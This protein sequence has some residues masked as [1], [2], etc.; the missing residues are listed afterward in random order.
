MKTIKKFVIF[1]IL[2]SLINI[3]YSQ[4]KF[5]LQECIDYAINNNLQIKQS[6]LNADVSEATLQQSKASLFPSLNANV[7]HNYNYGKTIDPFTNTFATEQVQSNSFSVS[8][9]VTIFHG[10]QAINTIKQ[11]KFNYLANKYEIEKIK[12]DISLSIAA[13]YLQILFSEELVNT[14]KNQ[15]KITAEKR[16]RIKKFVDAGSLAKSN[17]LEMEAQVASDEL[18]LVNYQNQLELSYLTLKQLMDYNVAEPFQI[19]KP[20]IPETVEENI[21]PDPQQIFTIAVEIQPEIKKAEYLLQS[22]YIGMQLARA[23]RSPLLSLRCSYGSGYSQANKEIVDKQFIDYVDYGIIT[24]DS[25][26]L[27]I[28]IPQYEYTYR[29]KPFNDQLDDNLNKSIG[30]YLSIPI[31]NGWQVKSAVSQAKI[32]IRS[33]ELNL[34]SAK[35]QL[36]KAIQQAYADAVSA[37]KKYKATEKALS[38]FNE[39]FKYI[40]EK[41]DYGMATSVEYNEAWKNLK[42]AESDLLQAKYDFIFKSK[43]LNFYMGKPITL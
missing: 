5:S 20:V 14:A 9:S 10:F 37:L 43:V 18:Q 35:N 8:S 33:A 42:K 32:G 26:T 7:Y 6:E 12:N 40:S 13:A 36:Q 28:Q 17:L 2:V 4:K 19:E 1:S 11:N 38:V 29:I 15:L 16:D 3:V 30:A 31:F 23:N 27:P 24:Y 41:Y 25:I 21:L 34:Q 22:S 39:A